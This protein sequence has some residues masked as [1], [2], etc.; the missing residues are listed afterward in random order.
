VVS[1]DQ[2]DGPDASPIRFCA[3]SLTLQAYERVVERP[4]GVVQRIRPHALSQIRNPCLHLRPRVKLRCPPMYRGR[5]HFVGLVAHAE[6]LAQ[7]QALAHMMR[8][9][10]LSRREPI[11]QHRPSRALA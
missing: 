1:H 4:S 6:C 8:E 7:A 2:F 9:R 3:L 10:G 11:W 5:F